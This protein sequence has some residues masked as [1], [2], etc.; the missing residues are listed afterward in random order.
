MYSNYKSNSK[1]QRNRLSRRLVHAILAGTILAS[2]TAF[3]HLWDEGFF[4][5]APTMIDHRAIVK[6]AADSRVMYDFVLP[7]RDLALNLEGIDFNNDMSVSEKEFAKGHVQLDKWVRKHVEM[8]SGAEGMF[9]RLFGSRPK[10]R[11]A[12]AEYAQS[13]TIFREKMYR[14][15][16]IFKCRTNKDIRITNNL[17]KM[18]EDRT[19]VAYSFLELHAVSGEIFWLRRLNGKETI[20]LDKHVPK[21]KNK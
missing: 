4:P 7:E 13:G 1:N 16:L 11:I 10:C 2:G 19:Q 9:G 15:Q 17:V 20:A 8:T 18:L 6:I 21:K 3:A 5:P 14:G 12:K